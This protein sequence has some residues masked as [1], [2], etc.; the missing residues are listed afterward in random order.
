[1]K[2]IIYSCFFTLASLSAMA[3]ANSLNPTDP[4]LKPTPKVMVKKPKPISKEFSFGI[5]LNSDGWSIFADRGSVKSTD[6]YP[7]RFYAVRIIQV[8]FSERMSPYEI[9]RTNTLGSYSNDKPTPFIY[10]KMNNFYALKIGY[11]NRKLIAGKPETGNVSIHWVY[12]GGLSLGLLK[13]YYIDV[14]VKDNTG[15]FVQE[16][17]KYTE[18]TKADFLNKPNII[19]SS[20][21]SKGIGETS[22]KPGIQLKTALHFDFASSKHSIVAIEAGAALD[23]YAGNV[24]IMANKDPQALFLSAYASFQFG[25]RW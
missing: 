10:G 7:D 24:Q 12:L 16:S 8:E 3:Q 6:K 14:Y 4:N 17:V 11:G 9:K 1:M 5:K 22:I 19:G 25:K 23:Y 15:A 2:G 21:F 13:P 18:K 20:G